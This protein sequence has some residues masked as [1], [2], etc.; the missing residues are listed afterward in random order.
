[1]RLYVSLLSGHLYRRVAFFYFIL[2]PPETL[3]RLS[4]SLSVLHL[5]PPSLSVVIA[6]LLLCWHVVFSFYQPV[7]PHI[8]SGSLSFLIRV[9]S[10]TPRWVHLISKKVQL[11]NEDPHCFLP[12]VFLCHCCLLLL[13][14]LVFFLLCFPSY[15]LGYLFFLHL[16]CLLPY[17]FLSLS[18]SLSFSIIGQ[19]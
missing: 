18:G 8:S 6:F 5:W 16:R 15:L 14:R 9:Q 3:L 12:P 13:C 11:N 10:S 2:N 17:H 7:S 4:I 1:M 19:S